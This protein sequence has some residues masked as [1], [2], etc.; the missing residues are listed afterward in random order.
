MKLLTSPLFGGKIMDGLNIKKIYPLSPM[1]EGMMFH[2]LL[3]KNEK[4]Y[5]EQFTFCMKGYIDFQTFEKSMNKIIENHDVFRTVFLFEEVEEPIQIVLDERKMKVHFEDISFYEE[6]KKADFIQQFR[7]K[8]RERTFDL[9]KDILL[10]LTLIQTETEKYYVIW[11]YHHIL[12]DGWCI[13]LILKEF[14]AIYEAYIHKKGINH[15]KTR[16]YSD[17]IHWYSNQDKKEAIKV[18]RNALGNYE[19]KASIPKLMDNP[20]L[21]YQLEEKKLVLNQEITNSIERI[22][23]RYQVTNNVIIQAAW[24][25]LL[26]KYN[27][28]NDVVFGSVVSGRPSNLVGV[29]NMIGLFIN[30]IPIRVHYSANQSF[31]DLVRS[32]QDF[33]WETGIY[34]FIPLRE[35]QSETK[36]KRE[37]FDHI[38]AF[39]NYPLDKELENNINFGDIG[40]SISDIQIFEQ[41]NYDLNIV[42]FPGEQLEIKFSYNTN[43]Y[44]SEQIQNMMIHYQNILSQVLKDELNLLKNVELVSE[45]EKEMIVK[46]FNQTSVSLPKQ[47]LLELIYQNAER[48]PT[49][50][51]VVSQEKTLTYDELI[52]EADKLAAYLKNKKGIKDEQIV[53]V[54]MDQSVDM[55]VA[56]LAVLRAGGV[57]LPIDPKYPV[58]RINYIME[59][60]DAHVLLTLS[61][62]HVDNKI[63]EDVEI[64]HLDKCLAQHLLPLEDKY[65]YELSPKKLAY[66]IYTSGSTGKPK[67]VGIEQHS[68]LNLCYWHIAYHQV[69]HKDNSTKYAGLGFDA[70]IWEIFPYLIAGSSI[71]LIPDDIR[72]DMK[73]LNQYFEKN[74]I[75]ISFLPT[76]ICEKFME[77]D[78]QSLRC[79][80]TG[81][82]KL[83]ISGSPNYDI[84][85]HYGP[86]EYT[87]VT[88]A[89]KVQKQMKSIPIGKPIYNTTCLILDHDGNLQ[90]VGV[91]GNLFVAGHGV[92]REY[93][94]NK[95]LT[96]QKFVYSKYLEN[97]RFYNTGDL[98]RWL[99]DGNID[100]IGR[101]DDQVNIKG[102]RME[103]GEIE[104][105]VNNHELI[106]KAVIVA[107]KNEDDH[108][109]LC[110]YFVSN[111]TLHIGELQEYLY[112]YLPNYMVPQFIVQVESFPMTANGKIDKHALPNPVALLNNK[113]RKEC[114]KLSEMEELT[115][116]AWRHVFH[117]ENV[118]FNDSFY[119][120]GGDSI[121]AIQVSNY[122]SSRGFQLDV[123][124]ILKYPVL[125]Q[126]AKHIKS[127]RLS[128]PQEMVIGEVELSPIQHWFFKQDFTYPHHWNQSMM[129]YS[130]KGFNEEVVKKVF[131][132]LIEHHDNLRMAYFQEPSI[133][134]YN[135]SFE[136]V[137]IDLL[138]KDLSK[139][140][141]VK[142]DI[143]SEC[144]N[145]H[146]SICL[147]KPL[148]IRLCNF[149]TNE[150][151]HLFVVIHHLLIDTVSWRILYEDFSNTYA[152]IMIGNDIS[153]P[154][155]TTSYKDW[156]MKLK[157]YSL[158]NKLLKEVKYWSKLSTFDIGA[159]PK[160]TKG[161]IN[162]RYHDVKVNISLNQEITTKLLT[163]AN[164]TYNTEIN[165]LLLTGLA[166]AIQKWTGQNYVLINLE[167]H[168][169]EN[170]FENLD[171]S[172]TIGWFTTMYPTV[173]DVSKVKSLD[174]TIRT[175]KEDQ[176]KIPNKGIGY[177]V[178]KYITPREHLG[179]VADSITVC[180]EI[181]FN[182][183]GQFDQDLKTRDFELSSYSSGDH[184]HPAEKKSTAIDI[185]GMVYNKKF[186]FS[187]SYHSQDF[188]AE[189]I[190]EVA[191]SYKYY[192]IKIMEH[193]L[194]TE[195]EVRT[196]NDYGDNSLSLDELKDIED[197]ILEIDN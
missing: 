164:N 72:L 2:S 116:A 106:Q 193:C 8:D 24:G 55:M 158:S 3:D 82:D 104:T 56:L 46:S 4:S 161:K 186:H 179:N 128:I 70:S 168:G 117:L 115:I 26:A 57:F 180:P 75:T 20:N 5:F 60:S 108:D 173:L 152:Q 126:L 123:K 102:I 125:H 67:G 88:T 120:L 148:L 150:G 111:I 109:S 139:S 47:S 11:S 188:K 95:E 79:I 49:K 195:E 172:R 35:I 59:D 127:Y 175:I 27:D 167:G 58:E 165:D 99:P 149:K 105:V 78:N 140:L 71:Y 177:G 34:D 29:E 189:V 190:K 86:T 36:L 63:K 196:P 42:V 141:D 163:E 197:M 65:I 130:K 9:S 135:H 98:A 156:T 77:I 183:L 10:R 157:E 142:K 192:L 166:L 103:L 14:F 176:R 114:R 153:L 162:H 174:Y 85:N 184:I 93:L 94:N 19:Q 68:L 48:F 119:L 40:I 61:Y 43:V 121:K 52:Q 7:I 39:E 129:I 16:P 84:I 41:T 118:G 50:C 51:A 185:V 194:K 23:K 28:T 92:A 110:C 83:K 122:L 80:L 171:I 151:D 44:Q 21:R 22:S 101:N 31:I 89:F 30:T 138:S 90:P 147:D 170:L 145:I 112:K 187:I 144:N 132:K 53:A 97:K 159:L 76:Q 96:S 181:S 37:L 18:W 146:A 69:T 178:L 91:T 143:L 64:I 25:I 62:L 160:K 73:R 124:T 32:L 100:Y 87:V 66:V 137:S 6:E 54:M 169:R 107:K 131:N 33:F 113:T 155:K 13:G 17:Y 1:Q 133:L 182:Y 134:Q 45:R 81:G 15:T 38:I 74:R 191:E 12:M 136:D 154:K